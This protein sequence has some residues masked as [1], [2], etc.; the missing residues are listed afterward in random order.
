METRVYY[1]RCCCYLNFRLFTKLILFTYERDVIF[2]AQYRQLNVTF[3]MVCDLWLSSVCVCVCV[4]GHIHGNS[5]SLEFSSPVIVPLHLKCFCIINSDYLIRSRIVSCSAG[6]YV[7]RANSIHTNT[8]SIEEFQRIKLWK[9]IGSQRTWFF[10][11]KTRGCSQTFR[12]WMKLHE[13]EWI[14][15]FVF[16]R[17]VWFFV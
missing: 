2:N 1:C 8:C 15:H 7:A 10:A 3:Q 9:Q 16:F 6:I 17:F 13:I 5:I 12:L 11:S 14:F 4:C